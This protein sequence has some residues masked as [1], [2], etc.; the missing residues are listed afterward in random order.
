M[1]NKFHIIFLSIS[2]LF[3]CQKKENTR[4]QLQANQPENYLKILLN[5][6]ELYIGEINSVN[7]KIDNDYKIEK[8]NDSIFINKNFLES[9]DIDGKEI[10]F[11]SIKQIKQVNITYDLAFVFNG[12]EKESVCIDYQYKYRVELNHGDKIPSINEIANT[13]QVKNE[14]AEKEDEILKIAYLNFIN[15][16]KEI[17]LNE[18]KNCC[19]DDFENFQRIKKIGNSNISKLSL[20]NDLKTN[21]DYKKLIIEVITKSNKKSIIIFLKNNCSSQKDISDKKIKNTN[22]NYQS[23]NWIG[24]FKIVA[25]AISDYD[26]KEIDLYYIINIDSDN[27]AILSIGADHSE[28]YWCEGEYKLMNKNGIIHARGKCDQD[29][30]DDFYLKHEN[31]K[32]YIKSKRFIN[33]DWQELQ[34]N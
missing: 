29:D 10:M 20:E 25:R 13:P 1:K 2:I 30:R 19:P 21:L 27:S 12:T 5:E 6:N 7:E 9:D 31:G 4:N 24:K 11:S 22:Q 32:T 33:Q 18:L 3:S 8:N 28:D 34:R 26:G 23:N 17:D 16:Y 15:Y 14:L